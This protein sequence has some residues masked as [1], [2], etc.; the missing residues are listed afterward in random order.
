MEH[1]A[2]LALTKPQTMASIKTLSLV[3]WQRAYFAL[4]LIPSWVT[5]YR[6]HCGHCHLN[7]CF[8]PPR[9]PRHPNWT[10]SWE[11]HTVIPLYGPLTRRLWTAPCTW[12]TDLLAFKLLAWQPH[13]GLVVWPVARLAGLM[14][15]T[16]LTPNVLR[17]EVPNKSQL[18]RAK[19]EIRWRVWGVGDGKSGEGRWISRWE[20]ETAQPECA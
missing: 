1:K 10:W 6:N 3:K 11:G 17:W 7:M 18:L 16:P 8:F 12:M 20:E 4:S 9:A 5:H 15:P 14:P 19:G 13:T 2:S